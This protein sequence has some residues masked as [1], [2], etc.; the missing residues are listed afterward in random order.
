MS[1]IP[2]ELTKIREELGL[3]RRDLAHLLSRDPSLIRQWEEGI[4]NPSLRSLELWAKALGYEL[5]L[6]KIERRSRVQ[7]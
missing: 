1:F 6:I 2:R 3:S 7:I 5:D 4:T